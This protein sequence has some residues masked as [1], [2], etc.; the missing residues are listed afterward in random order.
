MSQEQKNIWTS[1]CPGEIKIESKCHHNW[2]LA[3]IK[4][5]NEE[6]IKLCNH[7]S[8]NNNDKHRIKGGKIDILELI[9][10]KNIK[11]SALSRK[12]KDVMFLEDI[13][14]A[15]G[16]KLLKWKHLCK[17]KGLNTKGKTPNGKNYIITWND[18]HDFPIFGEDKK[19]SQSKNH[20]RIGI[21]LELVGEEYDLNNSPYLKKCEGCSR[22]ISKK[23]GNKECLIY[24]ENEYSRKIERRKDD[25]L[26]KPYETLNNIKKKNNWLRKFTQEERRDEIYNERIGKIDSIIKADEEF[27]M[28]IKNSIFEND[29]NFSREKRFFLIIDAVK[30]NS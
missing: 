18:E 1:K 10:K 14:E 20:K 21:H 22:N 7:E 3:A 2:I 13:L 5:L 19:R 12:T 29:E 30:K 6:N 9:D 26:I 4:M 17:E 23:K 11:E 27:I 25:G 24:L 16:V 28:L 8:R 15:D